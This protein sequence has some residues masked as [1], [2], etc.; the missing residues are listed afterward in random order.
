MWAFTNTKLIFFTFAEKNAFASELM[1]L[2]KT[3]A[4]LKPLFESVQNSNKVNNE[5]FMPMDVEFN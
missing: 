1:T 2:I 5:A 3:S 4:E